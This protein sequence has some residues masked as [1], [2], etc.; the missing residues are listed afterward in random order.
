MFS[1]GTSAA[2]AGLVVAVAAGPGWAAEGAARIQPVTVV[3][4][5]RSAGFTPVNAAD[6]GIHFSN[7]VAPERYL[8]NQI[9]LNGSGVALGDVDGDGRADVF[10]A[11]P[12]GRSALFLNGGSWKFTDATRPGFPDGFPGVDA[13]GAVLADLDGDAD[14]DLI[15][16]TIGQGTWIWWN[17]GRGVFGRGPILNPGRA[18]MSLALADADGDGDLDLYVANYRANSLRD[19]P[20]A[21][22]T[23]RTEDGRTRVVAYNGRSTSEPDLIGRFYLTPVGVKENGEPDALFLNEGAGKFTPVSWTGGAFLDASGRPLTAEPHDWGLSVMFRDVTGDGRPDLYVANDFESPDR[24]WINETPA[25]GPVRFKAARPEALRHTAAFSMGVDAADVNRDGVDDFLVL[26]MLSR[27][28]RERNVQVDGLPATPFDP[29]TLR[30][31]LQFS[32]NTLFL[33]RGDGTFAEIARF[34]GLAA[35][36]WSWSPVFLDVDLDGFEDLL[37]SNGHELEMMDADAGQRAERM[38]TQRRLSTRE[39]LDLR[40]LFRRFDT[41][42]AAFRNRGNLSFSDETTAWGFDTRNVTHGMAL[43]DLDGDG[44]LDVVQ[45]N[46][47]APPLLLRN[48]ATAPRI[49]IRLRGTGGNSAGIGA[50]IRVRGG[51]VPEQSQVMIS[52]GRYLGGDEAVRTFAAGD[53]A[54]LEVEVA[55]ASGRSTRMAG[56]PPNSTVEIAEGSDPATPRPPSRNPPPLFADPVG[57]IVSD[58]GG[59]PFNDLDRQP[60]LPWSLAYPGAGATWADLDGDGREDLILGTAAGGVPA[61]FR[62]REAGFE[63]MTNAPLQKPVLRDL[64]TVLVSGHTLLAGSSNYRDGRTNGGAIR[65]YDLERNAAGESVSGPDFAVGPLAQA[66]VDGDG[67][68][69]IFIGGRARAGR[70]P[71][72]APSLLLKSQGGRFAVFQRFEDAGLV[73]GAVFS[74]LDGDGDPDLALATEWGPLRLFRNEAGRFQP[75]NPAVSGPSVG[76]GPRSLGDLTGWWTSVATGDL[77]GDGVPDLVA[78]NRGWNWF[79]VPRA[80]GG[81]EGMSPDQVRRIAYGDF[82]GNGTVDLLESYRSGGRE[83]PVRRADVLFAV[84]PQLH[85]AFPSRSAFGEADIARILA[86]LHPSREPSLVEARWFA[87]TAFL[88]RGDHFEVRPLPRDAQQSPVFGLSLA[89]FD[90]DGSLDVVLAQNFFPVRPDEA[91]QDAGCGLLLTGDGTGSFHSATPMQSG[92]EVWGDARA[93]AVADYDLDGRPDLVMT[94]NFGPVRLFH[95]VTGKPGV[96]VR[97]DG[98]PSNPTA[99]G[100]RLRLLTPDRPGP[101]QEVQAGSGWLSVDGPARVLT[102]RGQPTAVEVHWPGGKVTRSPLAADLHSVRITPDGSL[103][104]SP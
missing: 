64:T 48:E 99:L 66:D 51:P 40:K 103:T 68:L 35:S 33:G 14:L 71:E 57:G 31:T 60:L 45:N 18:G 80:P 73:N 87:T 90:G 95:N 63:R 79:P 19:D 70:Y 104:R 52:G 32:A 89:D 39:L 55:W 94:Q 22:F 20:A 84:F 3:R 82:D 24:F 76:A 96:R 56:V 2:F 4:G 92:L 93:S 34:A 15:V 67:E 54:N 59:T 9:Y 5:T 65:I 101:I 11:A 10:L 43:A 1:K 37:I 102:C 46:L 91:R 21:K 26:D 69:E 6:S 61:V 38:K 72:P 58:S 97:L 81:P 47:N 78:G 7:R 83:L 85:D 41:P 8:T 17:Q 53:A 75:W 28:H 16:N 23:M 29:G 30:E 77:D 74:D 44:D 98:T 50:R 12:E 100:A 88:N 42:D 49:A 25:G 62:N 13:T 86:A 36:E 27:D